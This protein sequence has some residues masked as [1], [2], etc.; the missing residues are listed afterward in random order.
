[1]THLPVPY[2]IILSRNLDGA[3]L[4]AIVILQEILKTVNT[5][6]MH[7]AQPYLPERNHDSPSNE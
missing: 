2:S 6:A 7:Q 4:T 5:R 1:M 3:G